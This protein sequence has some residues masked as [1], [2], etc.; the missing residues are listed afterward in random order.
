MRIAP[1][2]CKFTIALVHGACGE[3]V[4]IGRLQLLARLRCRLSGEVMP[5]ERLG[6]G[7]MKGWDAARCSRSRTRDSACN[8]GLWSRAH[9]MMGTLIS[10]PHAASPIFYSYEFP[11]FL[12][13]S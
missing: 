7:T 2:A 9:G 12:T 6:R 10:T 13:L 11:D 5:D 1:F 4:F 3:H 8:S